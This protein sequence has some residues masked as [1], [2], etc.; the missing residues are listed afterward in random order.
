MSRL[1]LRTLA[2]AAKSTRP[3]IQLFG[4]DGTYALALYTAAATDSSVDKVFALLGKVREV[5][6]GDKQL[7]EFLTNPTLTRDDRS[8]VILALTLLLKL[9]KTV[10]NF[11]NVLAEN[12]RLTEFE[13][14]YSQFLV[15]NDAYKGVVEAKVTLAK[16]LDLK[17]LRRLQQA[18]SKLTLVG[19][20]KTLNITNEV[21]ADILGG[22]V[23]EVNE[24]TVDLSVSGKVAKLN[25]TLSE[26]I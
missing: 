22:L 5:V 9:D 26:L 8:A 25:Q 11:L 3:P 24:R 4:I 17:I 10:G 12:N 1:F 15:L 19:E 14:I 20:G 13:G 23:V 18:I 2:T 16:P 21:N 6:D 7:A